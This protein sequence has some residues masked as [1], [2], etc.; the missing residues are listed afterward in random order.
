MKIRK[1]LLA[2]VIFSS[3]SV[4]AATYDIADGDVA[5]L[6]D[7]IHASNA[8]PEPDVINLAPNGT[9]VLTYVAGPDS[10][11]GDTGLPIVQGVSQAQ[12]QSLTING[13]GSTIERSSLPGTPEFRVFHSLYANVILDGLVIKGGYGQ[14]SRC[15]G[16]GLYLNVSNTLL[17]NS[18]ITENFGVQGGGIC[19]NNASTL[20]IENSTISHNTGPGGEILNHVASLSI[21]NTTVFDNQSHSERGDSIVDEWSAPGSILIKSSIIASPTGGLGN[22]CLGFT[23]VSLGY[24]ILSD[25]TCGVSGPGDMIISDIALGALADNG[26]LTPTHA[27]LAGSPA[28][29]AIPIA[30]CTTIAGSTV[31]TD[32]RGVTRPFGSGCDIGAYESGDLNIGLVAYWPADGNTNDVVGG[33][34]GTFQNGSAYAPGRVGQSFD[35]NGTNFIEVP[36]SPSVSI[37]GPLTL[38]AWVWLN[39]NNVQQ[40]VI[41]KYNVPGLSG[42]LMRIDGAGRLV[43]AV[44]GPISGIYCGAPFAGAT[45]IPTGSWHH[46][47]TVHDGTSVKVY[48]DGVL[49]GEIIDP[50]TPA[51]GTSSLKI[52]A[53]GDD[54][55][56]RLNGLIDEVR[57][58][59]RALPPQE[60]SALAMLDST[61]PTITPFVS[62]TLGNNG[63]YTSDVEIGWSLVDPE[64]EVT[65][66]TGCDTQQVTE[67]TAGV[68]FTCIATSSGGTA[69]E[70]VTIKR[71][72]TEPVI[73]VNSPTD[74][75]YLL[76]QAANVSFSCSDAMSGVASCSGTAADGSVLDTSS[77][78]A[79]S[80]TV[81]ATDNAGNTASAT[82]NYTVE[83]VVEALY[84][85]TRAHKSGSTIPMKIRL[86]DANGVNVSSP[87]ILP[88]AISV[89]QISSQASTEFGDAGNSN[90]DFDFRYDADLNGYIFNLQTTG[91]G[92]GSYLLN[93]IVGGEPPI[94]SIGFQVRK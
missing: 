14:G 36:D 44:C 11:H 8:S 72:S 47:A 53:R 75:S 35:L 90:P 7:A 59:N 40:A 19:N 52:G 66:S 32:Q 61:P 10:W 74:G 60:I 71:D 77:T 85:Q 67:D 68:T 18:T 51:D 56:T 58:Y 64:S 12:P 23:P 84:D 62:G 76:N 81:N 21:N 28:I 50:V 31:S 48:L 86:V 13:N 24:N 91:F 39:E 38:A 45:V 16:G 88:H 34:H 89:I 26:G 6:I 25:G 49:D 57:L 43:G 17:R 54:A 73:T 4:N 41:E 33:N 30:D 3:I 87:A 9:Y 15:G 65:S 83:Y 82:V 93:F 1:L 22:D 27:L 37:A 80:F 2:T 79:K 70:S 55:N 42:Y 94:Y 92:T 78:G 46:V 20:T 5:G 69:T 29:D 63:W